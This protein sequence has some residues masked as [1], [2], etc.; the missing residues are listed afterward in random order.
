[1]HLS[2]VIEQE[3]IASSLRERQSGYLPIFG[4]PWS[5]SVSYQ[6][7][8]FFVG[9]FIPTVLSLV[10]SK[11]GC[12]FPTVEAQVVLRPIS[13]QISSSYSIVSA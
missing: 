11:Y 2:L 4:C 10:G 13:C 8:K 12:L 5:L 7:A 1:M 6:H 3:T 9:I